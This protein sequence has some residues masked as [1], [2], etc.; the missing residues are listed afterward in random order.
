MGSILP[1]EG[2]N[3]T[4]LYTG[5]PVLPYTG[6]IERIH[7]KFIEVEPVNNEMIN[8]DTL[9]LTIDSRNE[10]M[11]SFDYDNPRIGVNVINNPLL[12]HSNITVDIMEKITSLTKIDTS[13]V[14]ADAYEFRGN[15]ID[16]RN[17]ILYSQRQ[18]IF[19]ETLGK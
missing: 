8:R 17:S 4:P 13:K 5:P 1:I 14:D 3:K 2:F 16:D 10:K 12:N 19:K 15:K 6:K 11:A 7:G 18:D 9:K